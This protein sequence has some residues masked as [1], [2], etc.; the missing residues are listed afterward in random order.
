VTS[1]TRF[2]LR[3]RLLAASVAA[4]GGFAFTYVVKHFL[5]G[6]FFLWLLSGGLIGFGVA[7]WKPRHW[8]LAGIAT[9]SLVILETVTQS[10]RTGGTALALALGFTF[11]WAILAVAGAFLGRASAGVVEADD[12]GNAAFYGADGVKPSDSSR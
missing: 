7:L 1:I 5:P 8:L 11:F 9:P 3:D 4:A 2:A 6:F 10:S 12:P